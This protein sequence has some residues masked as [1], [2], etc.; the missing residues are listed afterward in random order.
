MGRPKIA[1]I[2]SGTK[3]I[4]GAE[5]VAVWTLEALKRD[6]EVTVVSTSELPVKQINQ[7]YGTSLDP[8]EFRSIVVPLPFGLHKTSAFWYLRRL[9]LMSRFQ[10]RVNEYDLCISTYYEMDFGRRGIQYVH[11]PAVAAGIVSGLNDFLDEPQRSLLK[12]AYRKLAANIFHFSVDKIRQN[13]TLVNSKWT[14]QLIKRAYGVEP[15]VVY[16]PVSMEYP[17]IPWEEREDGFV[18]IGRIAPSKRIDMIIRILKRV[19]ELGW[20]IHLHV[21][22]ERWDINYAKK[23]E[24]MAKENA[25][26]VFLEGRLERERLA[27]LVASHKY[28]IHG[29]KNEHFG[30][31][32]AEMVKAGNIVFVPNDGGQVEIVDSELLTYQIEEEAIKKIM[33]I[34]DNKRV[35]ASLRKHLGKRA[36]MFSA[37]YYIKE[38]KKIVKQVL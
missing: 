5:A 22:G 19:R 1:V 26:W 11:S 33:H 25:S 34:L 7:Y 14:G 21:V 2:H 20:N 36:G 18:C 30:I 23:I 24:K 17:R 28:G 32:V 38:I 29:M 3:W 13:V 35:Q 15:I 37:T 10:K 31:A 9:M 27:N 4:G 6:Y 8:G 12:K 16:P